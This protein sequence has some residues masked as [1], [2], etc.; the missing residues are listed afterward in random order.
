MNEKEA[1]LK[2]LDTFFT[3]WINYYD[4]FSASIFNVYVYNATINEISPTPN[5]RILDICTG[6]GEIAIRLAKKGALVTA[7]DITEVMLD[8]AKTKS[9][10]L[11]LKIDFQTLDARQLP[12]PDN[13]FEQ[14]CIGN[15]LHDMPRKVRIQVLREAYRV[16]SRQLIILDYDLWKNKFLFYIGLNLINLFETAY[17]KSY[18]KEGLAPLLLEANIVGELGKSSTKRIFP[19]LFSV[20]TINKQ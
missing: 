7:I 5:E 13:S 14:V 15:A 6:T 17:F 20:Q 4:L 8:K 1:Y 12:F 16:T 9:N 19:G 3:K 2:Y 11:G 10:A 18:A